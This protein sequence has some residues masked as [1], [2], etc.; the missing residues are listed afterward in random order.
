M[1]G[2][3][4]VQGDA[5]IPASTREVIMCPLLGLAVERNNG[6]KTAVH[7]AIVMVR[8]SQKSTMDT[9]SEDKKTYA[10][11]SE[12]VKCLLA[13][14][15]AAPVEVTIQGWCD[16]ETLLQYRLDKEV[17]VITVS[18]C[19]VCP[20]TNKRKLIADSMEKI[21]DS[22][23]G[24][25]IDHLRSERWI[26]GQHGAGSDTAASQTPLTPTS[27]RKCRKL[28]HDPSSPKQAA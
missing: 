19:T 6:T 11:T 18:A 27:G 13:D 5:V 10:V 28:S 25:V 22:E 20:T 21:G 1:L 24:A 23:M 9:L 7:K 12:G 14:D 4:D 26:A 16:F 17:A 8:G 2:F 3:C 15:D